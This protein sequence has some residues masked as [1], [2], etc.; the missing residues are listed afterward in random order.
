M[1]W[2]QLADLYNSSSTFRDAIDVDPVAALAQLGFSLE[3]A[4]TMVENLLGSTLPAGR[5]EC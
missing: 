2:E 5:R 4:T 1:S 3:E